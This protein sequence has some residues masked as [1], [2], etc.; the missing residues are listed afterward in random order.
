MEKLDQEE[1]SDIA[2]QDTQDLSH[3]ADQWPTLLESYSGSSR[4][5]NILARH[6]PLHQLCYNKIV[7]AFMEWYA[8][9]H[10]DWPT[11][12]EVQALIN[13]YFSVTKHPEIPEK[14]IK[15]FQLKRLE[16]PLVKAG[17]TVELIDV[18]WLKLADDAILSCK[19]RYPYIHDIGYFFRNK[20]LAL[21]LY[22]AYA[23][24]L[25]KERMT[26]GID[27]E[28]HP[29]LITLAEEAWDKKH[30]QKFQGIRYALLS[31]AGMRQAGIKLWWIF[32]EMV[33]DSCTTGLLS[34]MFETPELALLEE[35]VSAHLPEFKKFT[36]IN[37]TYYTDW[38]ESLREI[39]EDLAK[40]SA[41]FKNN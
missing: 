39:F 28:R 41:Y 29:A 13:R 38:G 9:K 34:F 11:S 7:D 33:Q 2:I 25:I 32:L 14:L 35:H 22:C 18:H 12:Q 40:D 4:T 19:K 17:D 31:R 26:R 3:F 27:I 10:H 1:L 6:T 16:H 23:Q 20:I 21:T 5:L 24:K 30:F 37:L 15:A 8:R 36:P